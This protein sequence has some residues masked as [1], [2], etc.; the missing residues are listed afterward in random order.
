MTDIEDV[1][2]AFRQSS[3]GTELYKHIPDDGGEIVSDGAYI[4][5]TQAETRS[6]NKGRVNRQVILSFKD[7]T[8]IDND[9]ER[10]QIVDVLHEVDH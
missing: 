2:L 5:L 3:S 10:E 8:V 9:I 6:F 7:G 4:T 1:C